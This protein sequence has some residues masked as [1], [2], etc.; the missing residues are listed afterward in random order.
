MHVY[1]LDA[2]RASCRRFSLVNLAEKG[3]V[4]SNFA[5]QVISHCLPFFITRSSA[6]LHLVAMATR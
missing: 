4:C 6:K 5:E 3:V 1:E 2:C